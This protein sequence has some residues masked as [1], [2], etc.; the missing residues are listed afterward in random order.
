MLSRGV[1]TGVDSVWGVDLVAMLFGIGYVGVRKEGV[2]GNC[3]RR[4]R[5]GVMDCR[6]AGGMRSVCLRA[7]VP[8]PRTGTQQR[9]LCRCLLNLSKIYVLPLLRL[10]QSKK[11][12]I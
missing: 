2:I 8:G 3:K 9:G 12:K 1:E 10:R 7:C 4:S 11:K 6:V 5:N